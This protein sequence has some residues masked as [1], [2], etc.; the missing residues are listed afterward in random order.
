MKK[1]ILTV[2]LIA[3]IVYAYDPSIET[4]GTEKEKNILKDLEQE[5]IDSELK[6]YR[7]SVEQKKAKGKT[8]D[9]TEQ[10]VIDNA[11]AN[12][13]YKMKKIADLIKKSTTDINFFGRV[14]DQ[15]TNPIPNAIVPFKLSH[16]NIFTNLKR[17]KYKCYTDENGCFEITDARGLSLS[18]DKPIKDGYE[19]T[20]N[21]RANYLYS[22]D[23]RPLHQPDPINPV[24]FIMRKIPKKALMFYAH[25]NVKCKNYNS[26]IYF[27][28]IQ[29]M[30]GKTAQKWF[31]EK[32][33][34]QE[35]VLKPKG[36]NIIVVDRRMR[37]YKTMNAFALKFTAYPTDD[38]NI[39]K[40]VFNLLPNGKFA[41]PTKDDKFIETSL[42]APESGYQPAVTILLTNN[43]KDIKRTLFLKV[44]A[45]TNKTLYGKLTLAFKEIE[46]KKK[47]KKTKYCYDNSPFNISVQYTMYLNV[48]GTR[49]LLYER[50]LERHAKM[51]FEHDGKRMLKLIEKRKRETKEEKKKKLERYKLYK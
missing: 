28:I 41:I 47:R 46:K 5:H 17:T 38:T 50:E 1:I 8:I 6:I 3:I 26:T 10:E 7:K 27:P 25:D 43:F 30:G 44:S 24:L 35:E 32:G 9:K 18:F 31:D 37:L 42:E 48:E 34:F 16:Y 4:T 33:Y 40:F 19:L 13:N 45:A 51:R 22:Y 14:V 12:F 36:E 11:K 2:V 23:R 21:C 39:I 20:K 49:N 15:S 29:R